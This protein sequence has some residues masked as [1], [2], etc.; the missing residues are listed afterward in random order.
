MHDNLFL[1]TVFL[2]RRSACGISAVLNSADV[3]PYHITEGTFCHGHAKTKMEKRKNFGKMKKMLYADRRNV[4]IC[5]HKKDGMSKH[6][7]A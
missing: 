1:L 3:F 7:Y 6:E 2:Q 5:M 4:I